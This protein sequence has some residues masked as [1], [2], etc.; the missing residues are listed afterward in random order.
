MH[1]ARVRP[2]YKLPLSKI[3]SIFYFEKI[4]TYPKRNAYECAFPQ[5]MRVVRI[6]FEVSA[7]EIRGR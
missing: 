1:G 3:Q 6:H 2:K 5:T 7:C 4:S